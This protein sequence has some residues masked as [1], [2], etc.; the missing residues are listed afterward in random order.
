[1]QELV[2][3]QWLTR[4]YVQVHGRADNVFIFHFQFEDD[5]T[6]LLNQTPWCF[7]GG[8]QWVPNMVLV[9]FEILLLPFGWKSLEYHTPSILVRF[10]QLIG[11]VDRI[12]ID[13]GFP[14]NIKFARARVWIN[15]RLPLMSGCFLNRD[16]NATQWVSFRFER[17]FKI[18]R[19]CG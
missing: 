14:T 8:L 5:R 15:P 13:E 19:N 2:N 6:Y 10:A 4:G 18:C 9:I 7:E 1:M 11:E 12:D 16:D 17:V 3:R